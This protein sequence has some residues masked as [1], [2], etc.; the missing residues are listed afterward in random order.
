MITIGLTNWKGH[1]TLIVD[2]NKELENYTSHFPFVEM[3]T[4]FYSIQPENNLLNWIDK[5]PAGFQFIPKAFQAM[6]THREWGDYF[7]S[8]A[9]MFKVFIDSFQPML[10]AKRI[11]AF[12]F[13]FPPYFACSSENVLYLRKIRHWMGDLPVAIEFRN[14]TWFSELYYGKTIEFLK[15]MQFIQTTVDQPQTQT[16]SIPRV[17]E[18]TNPELT[19]LRLHGRNFDGWLNAS[20]P[21]WRKTRTLYNYNHAEITEIKGY[22]EKLALHA[23]EVAVI[24]N[25]NSGGHAAGN[26][27]ELQKQLNLTFPNLAPQQMGLD[28]F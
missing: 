6:T 15:E 21:D 1:N 7:T 13:Q 14:H 19:L 27:K 8:E 24:F 10:D 12:L 2:K 26:A 22:V 16:N 25:N 23:K 18:V 20:N 9:L 4:S 3:D 5:T 11:K 28:L 17:L